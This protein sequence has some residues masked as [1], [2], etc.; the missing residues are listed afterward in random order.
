MHFFSMEKVHT[1]N[2]HLICAFINTLSVVNSTHCIQSV[3]YVQQY[4]LIF[5][6]RKV[7]KKKMTIDYTVLG[8]S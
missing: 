4:Y 6:D 1:S 5:K 7:T 2:Y 3:L 8:I